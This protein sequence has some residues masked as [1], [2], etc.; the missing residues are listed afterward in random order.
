V[1][2]EYAD[3]REYL[4]VHQSLRI[5]LRRFVDATERLD[6]SKLAAL[7]GP[8]WALFTRGL[9]HHHEVE[10]SDFFPE[11][12]RVRPDTSALIERLENEHRDLVARLDTVDGAIAALEANPDPSTKQAA[13]DAITAV[14]DF[15]VPHLD[16]E[17]SDLLPVAA[18]S[19]PGD[20]WKRI[21]EHALRS[22]PKDVLPVAAGAIDEVVRSLPEHERPPPPPIFVRFLVAVSW[23]KR[24]T[25]FI[26]PLVA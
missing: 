23:R 9:H 20:E 13:H 26:E 19:V 15:L 17:D 6:P 14:R 22:L 5:T 4:V 24:Y 16:M 8:R 21:S 1:T 7:L 10:D 11:I 3:T 2:G 25:K 12:L 18:E